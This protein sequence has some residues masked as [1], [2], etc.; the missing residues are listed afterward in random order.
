MNSFSPSFNRLVNLVSRLPGIGQK[1]AE[2][3]SYF[4]LKNPR[5]YAQEL[6]TE[7]ATIHD[8][9]GFCSICGMMTESDPC[10]ICQS[11]RREH[12]RICVV[13]NPADALS[14][15]NTN[16]YKGVYHILM[17]VISPL[18]GVNPEDLRIGQLVDRVDQGGIEE[19]I[20]ATNP[21]V[22]GDAT[23]FYIKKLLNGK[24]VVVTQIA[25]GLPVGGDLEFA[26]SLTLSRALFNRDKL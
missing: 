3:L 4:I 11:S 7:I 10:P 9:I 20:L 13:G 6:A 23:A 24:N 26:D 19:V 16:D 14:I 25:K 21:T 2:R 1:S 22:E 15:E 17:G 5:Q 18:N 12:N 8:K